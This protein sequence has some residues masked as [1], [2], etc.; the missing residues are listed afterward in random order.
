[1]LAKVVDPVGGTTAD[2]SATDAS[3]GGSGWETLSF[4]F[5]N[6][7]DGTPAGAFIYG[8]ILFFPLWNGSG[9]NASADTTTY[10]DNIT[11]LSSATASLDD[12]NLFE[13]KV[14]PNPASDTWTISTQNNLITSVEVFNLLGKRVVLQNNNS[15][16]VAISTQGLTSGIYIARITTEQGTKSV[17]LIKE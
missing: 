10:V 3:H 8:R 9:F 16:N 15:T 11:A 6:P 17:K 13:S 1:M 2:E 5:S 12:K 4:D 7:K 14:Y